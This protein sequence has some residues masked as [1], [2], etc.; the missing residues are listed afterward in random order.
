V[1]TDPNVRIQESKAATCDIL[2]GRRPR[3]PA[4][5]R[6]VQEHEPPQVEAE[7]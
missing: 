1:V 6:F 5:R 2:P 4:L 7:S 3:G